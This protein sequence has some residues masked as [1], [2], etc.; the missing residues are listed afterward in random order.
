[1]VDL[2]REKWNCV[3]DGLIVLGERLEDLDLE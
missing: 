2:A 1:M 3:F